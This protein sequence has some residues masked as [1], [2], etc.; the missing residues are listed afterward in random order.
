LLLQRRESS[1]CR[2]I[3][4]LDATDREQGESCKLPGR[5]LRST[6]SASDAMKSQSPSDGVCCYFGAPPNAAVVAGAQPK[7]DQK[8]QR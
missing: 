6:N 2:A 4:A 1:K 3:G 7:H 8:S 5:V